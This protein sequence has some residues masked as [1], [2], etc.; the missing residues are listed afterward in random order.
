ME[1]LFFTDEELREIRYCVNRVRIDCDKLPTKLCLTTGAVGILNK[2]VW[3]LQQL[4][5]KID[6]H[7]Y[8]E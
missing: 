4:I 7:L 5:D 3:R 2:E 6:L 8:G 1:T